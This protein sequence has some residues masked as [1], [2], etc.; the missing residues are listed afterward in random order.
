MKV[1]GKGVT[2]EEAPVITSFYQNKAFLFKYN[3]FPEDCPLEPGLLNENIDQL[4]DQ[5][6]IK[7]LYAL[8][9][10]VQ[11]NSKEKINQLI[12][13]LELLLERKDELEAMYRAEEVSKMKIIGMT[14]T[15]ASINNSLVKLLMPEVV[16]VEEAAEILEPQLL[17]ALT[18]NLKHLI[19][20]GDHHQLPPQVNTY[21]LKKKYHF[22][23]SM[24]QRLVEN[25]L[26]FVQLTLQNRM[27]P[28][29]AELLS[30][31]Y[32]N[33]KSNIARVGAIPLPKILANSS[34]FWSHSAEEC[35]E[36]SKSNPEEVDRAL[37]LGLLLVTY[38]HKPSEI[39]ILCAYLGQTSLMKR[40]LVEYMKRFP[41]LGKEHIKKE[42]F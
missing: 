2:K 1:S 17:V 18:P 39:T 16:L 33:L 23:T 35:S 25:K 36:R 24:M 12:L 5:D 14:I 37:S 38:G 32:P 8:L 21:T 31:I 34:Y 30:D 3:D 26:P 11:A 40:K 6:K 13:D 19:M 22:D 28:E 9:V 7:F 29:I 41:D 4:G 42:F 15:G 27:R 20:I 10:K